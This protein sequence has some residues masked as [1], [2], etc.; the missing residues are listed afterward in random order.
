[1]SRGMNH[2]SERAV[3]LSRHLSPPAL[4]LVFVRGFR[5]VT[6]FAGRDLCLP[7]PRGTADST[8]PATEEAQAALVEQGAHSPSSLHVEVACGQGPRGR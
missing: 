7:A 4:A 8:V 1:M 3:A 2:R 5:W 6:S